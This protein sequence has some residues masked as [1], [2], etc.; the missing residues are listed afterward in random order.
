MC[1]VLGRS[2]LQQQ[3]S[4]PRIA[5][6]AGALLFFF[7][8]FFFSSLS[9][10]SCFWV[11]LDVWHVA[12][13]RVFRSLGKELQRSRLC[14]HA[15]SSHRKRTS[16]H[17]CRCRRRCSSWNSPFFFFCFSL[18]FY[19][20]GI[21]LTDEDKECDLYKCEVSCDG[22]GKSCDFFFF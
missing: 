21:V 5:K 3:M 2:G 6:V 17:H 20:L 8:F 9:L 18:F 19:F 13:C 4:L 11:L 15:S 12:D 7:F 1:G 22:V 10:D 14:C 16:H